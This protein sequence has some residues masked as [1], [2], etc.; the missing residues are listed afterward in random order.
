MNP[1]ILSLIDIKKFFPIRQGIFRKV[2]GYNQAVNGVSISIQQGKVHAIVGESGSGKSTLGRVAIRLLDPDCGSIVFKG[3]NLEKLSQAELKP[4]RKSLQMIFQDPYS[5]L[6]PRHTVEESLGE[7]LL[8]HGLAKNDKEMKELVAKTLMEVGL[9]PDVMDRYPHQFSG[10]QQQRLCIGRALALRPELIIA[11][12]ALSA[13]D[14]SIQAQILNLLVGIQKE[15][16][17]SFLFISHDLAVVRYISDEVTVMYLGKVM[18]SGSKDEIFNNPKHPYTQALLASIPKIHPSQKLT[19]IPLSG[20]IPSPSKPP[21][22]CPFRTRC[23]FAK[24]ICTEPPPKKVIAG[25]NHRYFCIR[26]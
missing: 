14:V 17:L 10:G 20:E 2:I 11:D 16:Q 9:S 24:P 5:S 19:R 15:H 18:E 25:T 12:E 3:V 21:S 23:P 8:F 26:D 1:D 22:G 6:N 13:L 4:Y 7:G